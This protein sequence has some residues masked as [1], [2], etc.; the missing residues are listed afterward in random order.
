MIGMG[1]NVLRGKGLNVRWKKAQYK[2]YLYVL[3][4]LQLTETW[5][6]L[7]CQ[8]RFTLEVCVS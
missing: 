7:K 8:C 5:L 2:F 1:N 4:E 3:L 6:L